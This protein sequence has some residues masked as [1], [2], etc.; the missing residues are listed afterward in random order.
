MMRKIYVITTGGTIEKEYSEEVCTVVN[1]SWR[2][3]RYIERL[4][5]PDTAVEVVALMNRDSLEITQEDRV[6]LVSEVAKLTSSG[7]PVVITHGTDTLIDSGL[8]IES[9]L[10]DLSVPVILTGAMVPLA[11]EGSDGVQN[12]TES[13]FAAQLLPPGVHVVFHGKAL[14]VREVQKDATRRTFVR[15][16]AEQN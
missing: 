5:L 13:L 9:A 4:R 11:C 15:R 12:L 1:R 7:C 6:A 2:I 3:A 10:G 8:E 14:P 16:P